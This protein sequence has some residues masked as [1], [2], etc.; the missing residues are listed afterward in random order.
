[1]VKYVRGENIKMLLH[2][3]HAS[4]KIDGNI[5]LLNEKENLDYLTDVDIDILFDGYSIKFPY[6]RFVCDVERLKENEPMEKYGQGIIYRKDVYGNPIK[7]II[8]DDDVYRLYD[9]HHRLLNISVNR[10]LSLFKNVVII[11]CHSF[12]S[13]N[14]NDPNVCIGTDSFHTP[15]ELIDIVSEYFY[16]HRISISFNKPYSGTI[17]P[18]NHI[19]NINVKSI[20][21]ELNKNL[22]LGDVYGFKEIIDNLLMRIE[23]YEWSIA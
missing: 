2:I 7:R 20:M 14:I 18:S 13:S 3:P 16:K 4:R 21:L 8:S 17:I 19:N 6:S 23:H 11:D 9:E 15:K 1:M 10:Q 12:T 22:Y 5:E